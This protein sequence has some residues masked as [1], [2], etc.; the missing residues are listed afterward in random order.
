MLCLDPFVTKDINRTLI[1]L[2]SYNGKSLYFFLQL[3][4][5]LKL[6]QTKNKF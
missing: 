3:L 6:F 5:S 1:K 4:H 2:E